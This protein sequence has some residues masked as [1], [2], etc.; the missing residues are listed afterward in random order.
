[1]SILKIKDS[2]GNWVGIPTVKGEKGDATDIS[3][4]IAN[5]EGETASQAYAVGDAFIFNSKLYKAIS[6][7]SLGDN[8][9]PNTNCIQTNVI[10]FIKGT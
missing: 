3:S 6:F 4:L 10:N 2:Q 1:M 7:I 8:I 9:I 5:V